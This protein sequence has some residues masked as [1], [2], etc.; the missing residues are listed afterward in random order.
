MQ[1]AILYV[2]LRLLGVDVCTADV[3]TS[4]QVLDQALG[5]V[6]LPAAFQLLVKL[7]PIRLL[8][9]NFGITSAAMIILTKEGSQYTQDGHGGAWTASGGTTVG[10]LLDFR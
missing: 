1:L 2:N 5:V 7:R 3:E 6:L 4:N 9:E 10:I 8:R